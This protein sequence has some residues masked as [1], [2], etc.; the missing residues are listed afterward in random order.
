MKRLSRRDRV[1]SSHSLG[2]TRTSS[3]GATRPL[4]PSAD[5]GPGGQSVGSTSPNA[6]SGRKPTLL[7]L[8][9]KVA[10]LI[11]I[12]LANECAAGSS[13]TSTLPLDPEPKEPVQCPNELI[14]QANVLVAWSRSYQSAG[15]QGATCFGNV[16]VIAGE[17]STL[18]IVTFE[19]A[20]PVLVGVW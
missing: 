6:R 1:L 8:G 5:I 13:L 14:S 16:N 3:L 4:P 10:C 9:A 12:E 15:S 11:P 18:L 20:P 7:Q 2:Q 19:T 17:R